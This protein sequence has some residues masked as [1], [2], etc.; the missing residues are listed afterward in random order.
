[1]R[2]WKVAFLAGLDYARMPAD[3]VIA[4]LKGLGYEGI[5][6]TTSHFDVDLPVADLR[7]L[8]GK[9]RDAGMDVS[10]IMAHED[11][12]SLDDDAR[13][14]RIDRTVRAIHAAGECDVATVGTMTGPAPWDANAP[15]VGRDI[16]ESAAWAQV[17]E[18]YAAFSTAAEAA[19][20]VHLVRGRLRHA[21]ARLLHASL[22]DRPARQPG[23][24]GESGPFARNPLREL[25]RSVGRARMG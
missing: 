24:E 16:S 11:L 17:F 3:S 21:G 6:W 25:R 19:G 15:K 22:P 4:S 14:V 13:R 18:A 12:V 1:M 23:A 9:T 8:V 20:V 2:G 7:A 10:R 5:E